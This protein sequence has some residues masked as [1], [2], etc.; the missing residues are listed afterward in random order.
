MWWK[1][2]GGVILHRRVGGVCRLH[3]LGIRNTGCYRLTIFLPRAVSSTMMLAATRRFIIN[4]HGATFQKTALLITFWLGLYFVQKRGVAQSVQSLS[5]GLNCPGFGILFCG[6]F[7]DAIS[8]L[9]H[10]ASNGEVIMN[11]LLERIW[12][13][14]CRLLMEVKSRNSAWRESAKKSKATPV[15]GRGGLYGCETLRIPQCI[16]NRLADGGEVVNLTHRPRSTPLKHYFSAS[17]THFS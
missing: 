13:E 17:V 10:T 5:Y 3:L 9:Q 11:N 15:T 12:K 4:S 6:F 1:G 8:G 2:G 16:D 7:N 14:S